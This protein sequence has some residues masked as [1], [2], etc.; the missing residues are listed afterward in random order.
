M[1]IFSRNKTA[2]NSVPADLQQYYTPEQPAWKRMLGIAARVLLLLLLLGLLI[3]GALWALGRIN[4]RQSA[5][6]NVTETQQAADEAQ[7]EAEQKAAEAKQKADAAAQAEQKK[8][9]EDRKR[10][11]GTGGGATTPAAGAGGATT[12][13]TTA[14]GTAAPA[15]PAPAPT[16]PKTGG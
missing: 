15:S 4:N 8:A 6:Q 11:A 13:V 16:L 3:W 12:P 14:P 9:E 10:A 7:N 2:N 1:S 5:D